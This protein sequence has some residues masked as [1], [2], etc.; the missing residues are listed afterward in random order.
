MSP[1]EYVHYMQEQEHGMRRTIETGNTIYTIQLATPEY[2]ASRDISHAQNPDALNRR[3]HELNGS[4][5]F[6]ISMR[7]SKGDLAERNSN[8]MATYYEGQVMNDIVL[9]TNKGDVPPAVIHFENN[10]G[11]SP[12]NTL[13]AGFVVGDSLHSD[14]QLVFND[15]YAG[16]PMVQASFPTASINKLPSLI[17]R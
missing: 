14:I 12:D 17:I 13:V 16:N 11:L 7:P 1:S 6:L 2:M 4:L 5:F 9:K 8:S 15:R 10:L 3:V